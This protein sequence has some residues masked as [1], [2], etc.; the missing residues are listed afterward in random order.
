MAE[1]ENAATEPVLDILS[2]SAL[3]LPPEVIRINL[4]ER[5]YRPPSKPTIDRALKDLL[6]RSLV[7]KHPDKRGY[8]AITELGESYLSGDLDANELEIEDI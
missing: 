5:M 4:E 6:S 1:W 7:E 3:Y 2:E 8:Y